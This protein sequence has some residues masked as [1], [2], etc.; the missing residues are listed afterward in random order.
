M[1]SCVRHQSEM[2]RNSLACPIT[3]RE[4]GKERRKEKNSEPGRPVGSHLIPYVEKVFSFL[5]LPA[6]FT[7]QRS[8]AARRRSVHLLTDRLPHLKKRGRAVNALK[9]DGR[10]DVLFSLAEKVRRYVYRE[11]KLRGL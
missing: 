5:F 9:M 11:T 1:E 8:C 10:T 7:V 6:S 3:E 2:E 4:E